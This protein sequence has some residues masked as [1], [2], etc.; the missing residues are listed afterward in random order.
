MERSIKNKGYYVKKINKLVV[1]KYLVVSKKK[2]G[3]FHE[4]IVNLRCMV[5]ADEDPVLVN[6]LVFLERIGGQKAIG[7]GEFKYIGALKNF[8]F[9]G[10]VSLRKRKLVDFLVFFTFCC[11]ANYF[12]RNG[13]FSAG[14]EG[15]VYVLPIIDLNIF[16]NFN[17]I[18]ITGN[19]VI[20]FIGNLEN[21]ELRLED[22][23]KLIK[24]K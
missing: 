12:K 24:I 23:L 17:F 21:L 14:V 18:D 22:G 10:V 4:I 8:F 11:I 13:V 3:I 6:N 19:L 20:K 9:D 7:Y 1:Q 2:T 15:N 16:P 5:L